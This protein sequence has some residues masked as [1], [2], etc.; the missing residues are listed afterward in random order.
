[1]RGF[2]VVWHRVLAVGK[3]WQRAACFAALPA[4]L[5]KAAINKSIPVY[6]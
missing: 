3:V 5:E 2:L 6:F 4:N 1:M